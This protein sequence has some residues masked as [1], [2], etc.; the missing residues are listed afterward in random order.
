MLSAGAQSIACP[1]CNHVYEFPAIR[2]GDRTVRMTD[3]LAE[4][5]K[6]FSLLQHQL[7]EVKRSLETS[8]NR[9]S[10]RRIMVAD[11]QRKINTLTQDRAKLLQEIEQLKKAGPAPAAPPEVM[12]DKEAELELQRARNEVQLAR[13]ECLRFQGAADS[14]ARERDELFQKVRQLEMSLADARHEMAG[15]SL[16]AESEKLRHFEEHLSRTQEQLTS[17]ESER[18]DLR[19][20]L[21]E[22]QIHHQEV[23]ALSQE[24]LTQTREALRR[25]DDARNGAQRELEMAS[26]RF[27]DAE[28][29]AQRYFAESKAASELVEVLNQDIQNVQE[30]L[31][32]ATDQGRLFQQQAQNAEASLGQTQASLEA[33]QTQIKALRS[34]RDEAANAA[35]LLR[36]DL[37]KANEEVE[38]TKRQL[39]EANISLERLESENRRQR[40]ELNAAAMRAPSSDSSA[41]AGSTALILELKSE[42]EQVRSQLVETRLELVSVKEK[43]AK[44]QEEIKGLQEDIAKRERDLQKLKE[45]LSHSDKEYDRAS[46]QYQ[47]IKQHY[48]AV[49]Q[50]LEASKREVTELKDKISELTAEVEELNSVLAE[51]P[52]PAEVPDLPLSPPPLAEALPVPPPKNPSGGGFLKSIRLLGRKDE[53]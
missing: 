9:A 19:A 26:K 47:Q 41:P 29:L 49:N 44:S 21:Q 32:K 3:V 13:V 20:K 22:L 30:D 10:D 15:A 31:R 14:L 4:A 7:E 18:G 50:K 42:N 37:A 2:A 16:A 8:K 36:V 43:M 48:L 17:V 38:R 6:K 23:I 34:D 45:E 35:A 46:E 24:E 33:A 12:H 28:S 40:E 1:E 53:S 25:V 5:D 39:A 51:V 27:N 52:A 11:Q